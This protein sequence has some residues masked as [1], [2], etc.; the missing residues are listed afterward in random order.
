MPVAAVATRYHP[1]ERISPA[2]QSARA[3]SKPHALAG[4]STPAEALVVSWIHVRRRGYGRTCI[5]ALALIYHS[6]RDHH[7]V[8]SIVPF[9]KLPHVASGH[10]HEVCVGPPLRGARLFFILAYPIPLVRVNGLRRVRA[11]FFPIYCGTQTW[12]AY[13]APRRLVRYWP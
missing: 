10:D 6:A 1:I 8:A 2:Q 3:R 9:L 13:T 11:A 5:D 4:K 12:S 7:V